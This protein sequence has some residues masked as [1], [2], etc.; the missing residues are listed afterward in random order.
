MATSFVPDEP[1]DS[2]RIVRH[3]AFPLKPMNRE[4]AIFR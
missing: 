4:E 1:E 2:F 3:K